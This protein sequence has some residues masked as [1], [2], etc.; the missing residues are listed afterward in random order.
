[1]NVKLVVIVIEQEKDWMVLDC[2]VTHVD[3][4][5]CEFHRANGVRWG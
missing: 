2:D 1:M 3:K 5:T 4:T